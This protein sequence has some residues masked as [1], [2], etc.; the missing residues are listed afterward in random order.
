MYVYEVFKGLKLRDDAV[1]TGDWWLDPAT[2][3]KMEKA[4]YVG[5]A[6]DERP[7]MSSDL[8]PGSVCHA[9]S[10]AF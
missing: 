10:F 3:Q 4:L 5:G 9:D 2:G 8:K 1:D 7:N 6:S